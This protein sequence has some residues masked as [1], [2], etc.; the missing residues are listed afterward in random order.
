MTPGGV[1]L[2]KHR[3]WH[4]VV[5]VSRGAPRTLRRFAAHEDATAT[6]E[7]QNLAAQRGHAAPK[8]IDDP[9]F[10]AAYTLATVD[11]IAPAMNLVAE[12]ESPNRSTLRTARE[13]RR[14]RWFAALGIVALGAA[15]LAL[16]WGEQRKL[17]TVK[18]ERSAMASA[19]AETAPQ[20][21][22]QE[23]LRVM[24][25]GDST[26]LPASRVLA[27][28]SDALSD[29]AWVARLRMQGD[30][31]FVDG[32]AQSA[33]RTLDE[34]ANAPGL[35][36]MTVSAPIRRETTLDGEPVDRFEVTLSRLRARTAASERQP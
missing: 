26:R 19:L 28:L 12:G 16:E 15:P 7:A 35:G 21:L 18:A 29:E 14:W 13:V 24:A 6:L 23:R 25:A 20:R 32:R 10:A 8:H 5:E 3:E 17:A 30:S 11:A 33:A 4:E 27:T 36:A 31:V 34:L 9:L 22:M 2:V 1:L